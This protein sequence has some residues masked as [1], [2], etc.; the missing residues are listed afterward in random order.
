MVKLS[1]NAVL[2]GSDVQPNSQRRHPKGGAFV[3]VCVCARV[4]VCVCVCF[5]RGCMTDRDLN[6][7][8]C[9]YPSYIIY[10]IYTG[11]NTYF[12]FTNVLSHLFLTFLLEY[13]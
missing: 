8:H 12:F 9:M 3:C 4:C 13:S 10:M 2:D 5:G 7:L 6:W 11:K 1:E